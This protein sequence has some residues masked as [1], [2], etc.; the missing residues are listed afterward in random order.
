MATISQRRGAKYISCFNTWLKKSYLPTESLIDLQKL[1]RLH[2]RSA[3]E[4]S[5]LVENVM[6]VSKRARQTL[7]TINRKLTVE[8]MIEDHDTRT[9]RPSVTLEKV[10]SVKRKRIGW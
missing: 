3:E 1:A 6:K 5:M 4:A 8:E 7:K 10:H 2:G 9:A